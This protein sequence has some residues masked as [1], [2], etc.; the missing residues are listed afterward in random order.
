MLA[1]AIELGAG[2]REKYFGDPRFVE[3]PLR[4]LLSEDHI[5][6]RRKLIR[7]DKA[8]PDMRPGGPARESA[9]TPIPNDDA[10]MDTSYVCATDSHGNV[11]SA[12][13]S[14]A[15]YKIGRAHV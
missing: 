9:A 10:A 1:E 11:F 3:V 7:P 12:T 13:P 6:E 5:R 8:S 2:D 14:D 15:S 4:L